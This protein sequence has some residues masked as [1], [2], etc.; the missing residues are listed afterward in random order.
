MKGLSLFGL[1]TFSV[2]GTACMAVALVA[3]ELPYAILSGVC[4]AIAWVALGDYR[5][6]VEDENIFNN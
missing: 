6:A 3:K 5:K 4:F 2:M 1:I